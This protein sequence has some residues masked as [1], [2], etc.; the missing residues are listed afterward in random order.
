MD[1]SL[2]VPLLLFLPGLFL[3]FR[4]GILPVDILAISQMKDCIA[5]SVDIAMLVPGSSAWLLIR[6]GYC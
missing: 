3:C 1:E 2:T 6:R 5:N 4:G